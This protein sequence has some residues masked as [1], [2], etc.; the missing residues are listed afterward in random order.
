M[1][2]EIVKGLKIDKDKQEVWLKSS[3]NNVSP[4]TFEWWQ[5]TGLTRVL[6]EEG[7]EQLH[8][9]ILREYWGGNFQKTGNLYE[10]S[11]IYAKMKRMF[12]YRWDNVGKDKEYTEEQLLN[13][14]YQN[15]LNY[16]NRERG[17]FYIKRN[18]DGAYVKGKSVRHTY[19]VENKDFA[20]AFNSYEDAFVYKSSFSSKYEIEKG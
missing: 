11:V 5:C 16:K 14:L 6:K 15:W 4:K 9:K 20:K 2:Y 7:I 18:V 10:K 17:V 19:L 8:K 1:S 3:S 12:P 13:D